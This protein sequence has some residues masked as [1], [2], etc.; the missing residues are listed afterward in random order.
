M[1]LFAA[2]ALAGPLAAQ[3]VT[4]LPAGTRQTVSLDV[5][6]QEAVVTR[7]SYAWHFSSGLVYGRFTLPVASPDFRD[8]GFEAGGQTTAIAAGNWKLMAS[9]AP[10]VRMTNND[11]F[12]A[13]GLGVHAALM[14][15]YQADRWG[16]ML[17]LGYEKIV[18]THIHHSS[19][20]R[21]LSYSGARDGWYSQT[22]GTLQTGVR[23]GYRIVRVELSA[24]L[25]VLVTENLNRA[26]P[27]F[28][29]TVGS[30]YAF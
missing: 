14:P 21:N 12:S 10:V 28:Y 23:G 25:G 29:L 6:F 9:L 1:V 20:Y 13:T 17:D 2:A 15:G 19:L 24:A 22:A 26:T 5:G 7:A 4:N 3:E 11:F 16:L 18:A 30:S 27:P 8:F